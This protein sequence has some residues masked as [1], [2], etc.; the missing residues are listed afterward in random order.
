M[1]IKGKNVYTGSIILH[2]FRIFNPSD[3]QLIAAGYVWKEPE[4]DNREWVDKE[5]FV[6]AV[7]ELVPAEAIPAA[8]AEAKTAKDAIVGMAL[9]ATGAAPGNSVDISDPRVAQWL[10]VG[11]VTV[12]EVKEKMQEFALNG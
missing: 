4:V 1:W 11:G 6:N 5:L 8:L 10:A 9:F 2:G 7:Y 12:D 3:T